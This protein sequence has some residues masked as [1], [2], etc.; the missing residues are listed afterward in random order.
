MDPS[1]SYREI[2]EYPFLKNLAEY[3]WI[4]GNARQDHLTTLPPA[5]FIVEE[6]VLFQV[7]N[8]PQLN[9]FKANHI[10]CVGIKA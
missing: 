6:R 5:D 4:M 7:A 2:Q 10:D 9:T 1:E 8:K 3:C